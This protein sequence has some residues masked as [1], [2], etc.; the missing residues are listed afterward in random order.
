MKIRAD[1]RPVKPNIPVDPH[2]YS[3]N[4]HELQR[5]T[6]HDY[7]VKTLLELFFNFEKY[8]KLKIEILIYKAF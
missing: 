7:F 3:L 5:D 6:T 1:T 8:L 4:V 2:I